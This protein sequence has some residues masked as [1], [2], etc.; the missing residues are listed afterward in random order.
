MR[1]SCPLQGRRFQRALLSC[2]LQGDEA[3]L[4]AAGQHP[5]PLTDHLKAKISQPQRVEEESESAPPSLNS[6]SAY[7]IT[8]TDE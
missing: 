5:A 4:P 2:C 8:A 7:G 6:N 1:M 3:D